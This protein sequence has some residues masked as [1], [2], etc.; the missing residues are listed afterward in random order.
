MRFHPIVL[1]ALGLAMLAAMVTWLGPREGRPTAARRRR[2][3]MVTA[4]L[5]PVGT[6]V[7]FW[8]LCVHMYFALGAWPR[9]IGDAGFPERLAVHADAALLVFGSLLLGTLFVL[10]VA[11]VVC[12]LVPICRPGLPALRAF[13][14]ASAAFFASMCPAPGGF[15]YWWWD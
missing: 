1:L 11:A 8:S 5:L 10:P 13:A 14:G 3:A 2:L 4:L 15:L 7:L 9:V 12:C 6:T